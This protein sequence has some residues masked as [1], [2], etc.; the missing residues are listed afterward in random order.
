MNSRGSRGKSY[1]EKKQAEN[2]PVDNAKENYRKLEKKKNNW[3]FNAWLY[4]RKKDAKEKQ[5]K[6]ETVRTGECDARENLRGM[7]RKSKNEGSHSL[8]LT[9]MQDLIWFCA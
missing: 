8:C 6:L 3:T 5:I 2:C 7:K 1:S 9:E 4:F